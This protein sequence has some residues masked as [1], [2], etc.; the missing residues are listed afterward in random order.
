LRKT[1]YQF[2]FR[3]PSRRGAAICTG[4][5]LLIKP[6]SSGG[7]KDIN[8]G[9]EGSGLS[10]FT[11]FNGK[12]YFGAGKAENG[13]E[14]W[15]SDGT[16]AGT[17]L[18]A[19]LNPYYIYEPDGGPASSYPGNFQVVN[20][21]LYFQASVLADEN[22]H[23]GTTAR[24]S[25]SEMP[26]TLGALFAVRGATGKLDRVFTSQPAR[27]GIGAGISSLTNV[28]GTLYLYFTTYSSWPTITPENKLYASDGTTTRLLKDFAR[29]RWVRPGELTPY[30]GVVYF[31]ADDGISGGEIWKT[32]GTPAG[33]DKLIEDVPGPNGT[34]PSGLFIFGSALYF[35]NGA[36]GGRLWK[37][38]LSKP[39]ATPIRINAGGGPTR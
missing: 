37:Y 21:V 25:N 4:P 9:P 34:D 19:D 13:N 15:V 29:T 10:G 24:A 16:A 14:P 23:E 20:G 30:N 32:E 35:N 27:W 17:L 1:S 31:V 12:L 22:P 5:L 26:A 38:D 28:N 2:C 39:Q 36:D 6:V 7:V 8:P 11:P 18:L 3:S 33:T